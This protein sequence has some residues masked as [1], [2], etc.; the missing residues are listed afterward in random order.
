MI[1]RLGK[2]QKRNYNKYITEEETNMTMF[3]TSFQQFT[4]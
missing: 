3:W 2:V 4:A 1:S